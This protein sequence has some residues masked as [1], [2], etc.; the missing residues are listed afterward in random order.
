MFVGEGASLPYFG[1]VCPLRRG[2][3]ACTAVRRQASQGLCMLL[4]LTWSSWRRL[5][6]V[7]RRP[8]ALDKTVRVT[9]L[10]RRN[11]HLFQPCSYQVAAVGL[12]LR[13][14]APRRPPDHRAVECRDSLGRPPVTFWNRESQGG[15]ATTMSERG[16][17]PMTASLRATT[18][19]ALI[20]TS[21]LVGCARRPALTAMTA[22]AR[23]PSLP[24]RRHPVP[25]NAGGTA[26]RRQQAHTPRPAHR[27]RRP[28]S[29]KASRTRLRRYDNCNRSFRLTSIDIRPGDARPWRPT[30]PAQA[31]DVLIPSEGQCDER[32]PRIQPP[33]GDGVPGR[34]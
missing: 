24:P 29:R 14:L 19:S 1:R 13:H 32:A 17:H 8:R 7:E 30:R 16:R 28:S 26:R 6:R 20:I 12:V 2:P 4:S 15:R 23:P 3:G 9:L 21:I 31:H 5:R 33:L 22:P 11:H 18:I 25:R 34:P 27:D 10:D